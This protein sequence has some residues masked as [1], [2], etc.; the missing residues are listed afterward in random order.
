MG[1]DFSSI[2]MTH[3]GIAFAVSVITLP[4]QVGTIYEGATRMELDHVF[5][6]GFA[7]GY[8]V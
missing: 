5:C 1:L 2:E 4:R 3:A 7:M 8:P 6:F